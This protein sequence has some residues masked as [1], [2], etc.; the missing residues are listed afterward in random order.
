MEADTWFGFPLRFYSADSHERWIHMTDVCEHAFLS[1]PSLSVLFYL[2]GGLSARLLFSARV[3]RPSMSAYFWL[4]LLVFDNDVH[5]VV[6]SSPI[7]SPC[8]HVRQTSDRCQ[9]VTVICQSVVFRGFWRFCFER[10]EMFPFMSSSKAPFLVQVTIYRR[11]RIGRDGGPRI[12]LITN[13]ENRNISYS[14]VYC[15][16]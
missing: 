1:R 11:V 5:A 15:D 12:I 6:A 4:S 3:F 9:G 7:S 2:P 8:F 16:N 13:R 10:F 14:L